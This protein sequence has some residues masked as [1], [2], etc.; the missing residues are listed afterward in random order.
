MQDQSAL[1]FEVESVRDLLSRLRRHRSKGLQSGT[2]KLH[3]LVFFAREVSCWGWVRNLSLGPCLNSRKPVGLLGHACTA[4]RF[5]QWL[6]RKA[7]SFRLEARISWVKSVLQ[8]LHPYDSWPQLLLDL[9]HDEWR[10]NL[11]LKH[12]K[13]T[14]AAAAAGMEERITSHQ[15]LEM[16]TKYLSTQHVPDGS[17]GLC[18][19]CQA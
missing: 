7:R 10:A 15:C 4:I 5:K 8:T 16:N 12:Y 17:C 3:Q 9:R 13:H 2:L 19:G 11:L 18:K 1:P 14:I 6:I